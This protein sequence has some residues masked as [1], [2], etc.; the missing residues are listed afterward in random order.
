MCVHI[1]HSIHVEVRG[2]FVG[3]NFLPDNVGLR[4][5]TLAFRLGGQHLCLLSHLEGTY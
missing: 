4:D 2:Y 3:A 5:L 1:C